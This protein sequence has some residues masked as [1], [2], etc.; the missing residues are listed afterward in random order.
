MFYTATQSATRRP[1]RA[2]DC[3]FFP[4][5]LLLAGGAYF[6]SGSLGW[7]WRTVLHNTHQERQIY[8]EDNLDPPCR[9]PTRW[10]FTRHYKKCGFVHFYLIFSLLSYFK[11][12]ISLEMR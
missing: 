8:S 7:R 9:R 3:E 11:F 1:L 4:A 6:K 2:L 10:I 12:Y 5:G